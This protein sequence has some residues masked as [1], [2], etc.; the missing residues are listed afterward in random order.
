MGVPPSVYSWTEMGRPV[1]LF[2][3]IPPS[4]LLRTT[5]EKRAG[6]QLPSALQ[7]SPPSPHPVP[8]APHDGGPAA[9]QLTVTVPVVKLVSQPPPAGIGPSVSVIVTVN[10]PGIAGHV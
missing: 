8:K 7:I 6:T 10:V 4:R 2:G 1:V 3:I 5:T 9:W